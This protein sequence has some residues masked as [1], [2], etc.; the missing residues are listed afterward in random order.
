MTNFNVIGY[1]FQTAKP[2]KRHFTKRLNNAEPAK[3]FSQI[4]GD[5]NFAFSRIILYL[6]KKFCKSSKTAIAAERQ[7]FI[8]LKAMT[9][10]NILGGERETK[11]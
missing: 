5:A 4:A 7:N 11:I 2:E 9:G 6:L 1:Y 10:D 3:N 8:G